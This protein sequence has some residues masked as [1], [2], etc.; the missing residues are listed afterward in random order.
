MNSESG[1]FTLDKT[2]SASHISRPLVD[3]PLLTQV[4]TW[5]IHEKNVF[6]LEHYIALK[7]SDAF[8]NVYRI[9]QQYTNW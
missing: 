8:S 5:C 4:R 2:L 1:P 7:S 9:S 3:G 6:F